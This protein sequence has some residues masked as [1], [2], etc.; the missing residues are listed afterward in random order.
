MKNEGKKG[1]NNLMF[2]VVEGS[3]SESN[4]TLNQLPIVFDNFSVKNIWKFNWFKVNFICCWTNVIPFKDWLTGKFFVVVNFLL[5]QIY[6]R[7][8]TGIDN[9][10]KKKKRKKEERSKKL[11]YKPGIHSRFFFLLL[12]L[13]LNQKKNF[14]F[15][16]FVSTVKIL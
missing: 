1:K 16:N 3:S 11:F 7:R 9:I 15:L 5:F 14:L 10:F 2:K 13:T 8:Q 4:C 6:F 12:K